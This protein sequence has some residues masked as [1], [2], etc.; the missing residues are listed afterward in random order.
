MRMHKLSLESKVLMMDTCTSRGNTQVCI[1]P[2]L[3][4]GAVASDKRLD[5]WVRLR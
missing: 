4:T 5:L 2:S 3:G 1:W